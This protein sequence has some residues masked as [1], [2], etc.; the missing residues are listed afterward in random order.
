[1]ASSVSA[2]VLQLPVKSKSHFKNPRA[3]FCVKAFDWYIEFSTLIE[4]LVK[5]IL[6]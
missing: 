5:I 3:G 2:F 4:Q 6:I 1:M